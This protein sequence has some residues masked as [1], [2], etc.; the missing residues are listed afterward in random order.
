MTTRTA[1]QIRDISVLVY[2]D[3]LGAD[4]TKR[5]IEKDADN[6]MKLRS[7]AVIYDPI[8]KAT[9][10]AVGMDEIV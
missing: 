10:R 5:M 2:K 6:G 4:D 9:L 7:R 8:V 1:D 3:L